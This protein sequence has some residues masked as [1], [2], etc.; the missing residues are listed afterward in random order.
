MFSKIFGLFSNDLAIDLGT[1][2]TLVYA[3]GQGIV[4][5]EPSVVA[6]Q[7]DAR[8]G[9]RVQLH[10]GDMVLQEQE[11]VCWEDSVEN[12]GVVTNAP[13]GIVTTQDTKTRPTTRRS[14]ASMPRASPTPRTAP[15]SV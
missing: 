12:V 10:P 9:K 7:K 13:A 1:A 8:G 6:V 5:A 14:M 4:C 15:T 3:A 11:L 2:N